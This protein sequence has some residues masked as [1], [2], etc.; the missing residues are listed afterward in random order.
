MTNT[1]TETRRSC[2]FCTGQLEDSFTTTTLERGKATLIVKRVPA[3]VCDACGETYLDEAILA[4]L[5]READAAAAQ[6]MAIQVR[7]YAA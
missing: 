1:R 2:G 5:L 6:G 3:R 7:Y 4:R